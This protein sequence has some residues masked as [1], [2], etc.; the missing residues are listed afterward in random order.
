MVPGVADY[1]N[2]TVSTFHTFAVGEGRYVVHNCGGV[3]AKL[4]SFAQK[5]LRALMGKTG[6][7]W[8][9]IKATQPFRAGT[10]IPRSFTLKTA[11]GKYWVHGHATE[12]MAEYITGAVTRGN[13][14]VVSSPLR[15]QA[16]L[17]SFASAVDGVLPRLNPGRN[18]VES[19]GWHLGI[20]TSSKVIFHALFR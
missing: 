1:Y 16:L 9:R 17:H 4:G 19:G 7:V 11:Q 15:S 10:R 13:A 6:T 12:H 2:L 8:D 20:D 3:L 14:S 5:G 18:I